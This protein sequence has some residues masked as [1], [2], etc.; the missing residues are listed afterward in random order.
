VA[1]GGQS[2]VAMAAAPRPYTKTEVAFATPIIQVMSRLNTW[3]Y[4]ATNGRLGGRFRRGAPVLLLTT[5][6]RRSGV[7]RVAP[8]IYVR[9]G[10]RL[11]VI[12]SQGGMDHHPQWY[13]NLVAHADVEVQ[14]G[15]AVRPMR[16][17]TASREEKAALWPK[18]VAVYRD[19][20]DYQARTA[21]DI[22]VV[23]LEPR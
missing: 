20:D 9:D 5:T 3:I 18:A 7:R 6:G 2:I 16:A 14:I 1:R 17:R 12:A 19:Y 4:R 21:R 11:V 8:L 23:V 15:A 10:E 22:P 13:R